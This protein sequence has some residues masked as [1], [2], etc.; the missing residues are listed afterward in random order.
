MSNNDII[1][2]PPIETLKMLHTG[3][4]DLQ[5]YYQYY[6]WFRYLSGLPPIPKNNT[7]VNDIISLVYCREVMMSKYD[8]ETYKL[9]GGDI[10]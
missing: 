6:N 8:L 3:E 7:N 1:W 2:I 5:F 4:G 10:V 9:I